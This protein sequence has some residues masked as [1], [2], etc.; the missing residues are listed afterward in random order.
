MA[1]HILYVDGPPIVNA[2]DYHWH[3]STSSPTSLQTR[4]LQLSA[5]F[6]H[7]RTGGSHQQDT[8]TLTHPPLAE[9][10]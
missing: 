3:C 2:A 8:D 5:T 4:Q 9:P 10:V 7:I 6:Q 1:R